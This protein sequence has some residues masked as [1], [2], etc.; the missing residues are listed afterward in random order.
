M[1]FSRVIVSLI[2]PYSCLLFGVCSGYD[3]G[4]AFCFMYRVCSLYLCVGYVLSVQCMTICVCYRSVCIFHFFR[5]LVYFFNF[6][7]VSYFNVLMFLKAIV[8]LCF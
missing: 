5:G 7:F 3:D 8:P 4:G 6:G 2:V 1:I